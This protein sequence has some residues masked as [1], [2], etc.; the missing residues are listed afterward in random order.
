MKAKIEKIKETLRYAFNRFGFMKS[1]SAKVLGVYGITMFCILVLF[2]VFMSKSFGYNR[3]YQNVLENVNRINYIKTEISAQPN[4]LM[5]LCMMNKNVE[6]S[7]EIEIVETML[8]NLD[9]ISES[10]GSDVAFQGNQ[11]MIVSIRTPLTDYQTK[12]NEIVS[13]G[14]DG[15][16]PTLDP[17][18]TTKIQELSTLN[19][20]IS[21]YCGSLITMEVDRSEVVQKQVNHSF[22]RTIIIVG[23]V[24]LILLVFSTIWCTYVVRGI[25]RRVRSLKDEISVVAKGDLSRENIVIHSNDEIKELSIAFDNMSNSLR[26]IIGKMV[27]VT[28]EIDHSTQ[29][30]S[31]SVDINSKG[32]MEVSRSIEQMSQSMERQNQMTEETLKQVSDMETV[33]NKISAGVKRI[34]ENADISMERAQ[35][36]SEDIKQYAT[37]LSAVNQIMSQLSIVAGE[38]H[39]ST[40]EMNTIIESIG[41]ISAQTTLLSLN[42]SIEAARAGEA[43][44]GFAVVATEIKKLADDTQT[45]ANRIGCIIEQVQGNVV[46]MTDKMQ[47]GLSQLDKSNELAN[48]TQESFRDIREGTLVVNEDVQNIAACM[49]EMSQMVQYVTESVRSITETIEQNTVATVDIAKTVEGETGSLQEVSRTA[50]DLETL[51]QELHEVVLEFRLK[52]EQSE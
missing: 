17:D 10:I 5:S 19:V 15:C 35:K 27:R 3:E 43:G 38:L 39:T 36:G 12:L 42:A 20:S 28:N 52:R 9:E 41:N 44:R 50:G 47:A 25:T 4:R 1:I 6:E 21:N 2:I 29:V 34:S 18:I 26:R 48:V 31:E 46:Q 8:A 22:T 32:S 7:G 49:D 14:A 11:G 30:V 40:Q 51:A 24:F 16:Y 13:L 33:S 45:A 37:Q 23:V